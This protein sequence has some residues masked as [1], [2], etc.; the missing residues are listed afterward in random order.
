MKLAVLDML[1]SEN[2]F[3]TKSKEEIT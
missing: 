2:E 1:H 3:N